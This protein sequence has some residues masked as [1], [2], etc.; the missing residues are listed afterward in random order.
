MK[1]D[2]LVQGGPALWLILLISAVAGV[3]FLQRFFELH[4]AQIKTGDFIRGIFNI[5]KK[6]NIV[7]A[8]SQCEETPG[9][10][11]QMVR[12]A[13]LEREQ[14]PDRVRQVMQE[15]G[16]VEIPRL[17]KNLTLLLT[18]AQLAPLAGLL[19]TVLGMLSSL[20]VM[21]QDA[22]QVYS[23]DL[24]Q[25]LWSAL[26]TTAA[27]LAVAIPIYA[28]YNLLTSRVE[29]ILLDMD[30]VFGEIMMNIPKTHSAR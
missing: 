5:V 27:G 23:G 9:P 14:G 28:G 6:G 22:P 21:I 18:L 30:Q 3:V 20:Q 17:E 19:G 7:E 16:L 24:S 10:V 1:Y 11:A 25:G 8:V 4:R 29:S 2:M 15:V 12:M 26:L 13:I